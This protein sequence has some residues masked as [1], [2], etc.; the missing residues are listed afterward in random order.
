VNAIEQLRAV[1][2]RTCDCGDEMC[3]HCGDIEEQRDALAAVDALY[4]AAK[5]LHELKR[6][7]RD[8]AYY[9]KKQSAWFALAA[10]VRR[11][12]GQA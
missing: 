6:G 1:T 9:S 12:E 8:A 2:E 4:Q 10:A 5:A 3:A 11:V 7:P